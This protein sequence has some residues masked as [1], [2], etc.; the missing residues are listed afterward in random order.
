MSNKRRETY[1]E[2]REAFERKL[3]EP[4]EYVDD[5]PAPPKEAEVFELR[6]WRYRRWTA[7][8]DKTSSCVRY[9]PT[10]ADKMEELRREVALA[11][12]RERMRCD[13]LGIGVYDRET[14]DDV[15]KRQ[16]ETR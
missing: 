4:F 9:E 15:V 5:P 3:K 2:L 1:Q 11:A 8:P 13:P 10:V 6:P 16:D 7:E 14:I 12:R